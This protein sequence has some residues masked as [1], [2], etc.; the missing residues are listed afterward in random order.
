MATFNEIAQSVVD[1]VT[2]SLGFAIV[3]LSTG[4]LL[5]ASHKANYLTQAVIDAVVVAAVDLFR[6][7]TITNVEQVL[8]DLRGAEF[9]RLWQEVQVTSKKT[10]HFMLVL[11]NKPDT[12]IVLITGKRANLGLGWSAVRHAAPQ[13]EALIP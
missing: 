12:L 5:G 1:S 10:F 6:G 11:P 7:R 8:A 3:D 4:E 13:V 9:E 2:D